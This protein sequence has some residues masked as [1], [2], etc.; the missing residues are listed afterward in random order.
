M[1]DASDQISQN[2]CEQGV[3]SEFIITGKGGLP[4]NPH[5]N[6]KSDEVRVDLVE[7]VP[8]RQGDGDTGR[9]GEEIRGGKNSIRPENPTAEAVPAMGWIF[10]DKGEVMLTSYKTTDTE[11]KRSPQQKSNSCPAL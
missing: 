8:S 4:S 11:I 1:G 2:P 10:N 3:G 5:E 6:L 7:P 9:Q